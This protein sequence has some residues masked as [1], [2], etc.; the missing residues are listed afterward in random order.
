MERVKPADAVEESDRDGRTSFTMLE[1]DLDIADGISRRR[2]GLLMGVMLV[3]LAEPRGT[4]C[5]ISECLRYR[6]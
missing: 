3:G 5:W 2:G 6:C 4:T 1:Y